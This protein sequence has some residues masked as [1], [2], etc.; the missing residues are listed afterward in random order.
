MAKLKLIAVGTTNPN[1]E[2]W[3]AWEDVELYLA[4][5]IEEA[6]KM[7]GYHESF[8]AV[9]VDMTKKGHVM[10]YRYNEFEEERL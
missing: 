3:T 1:P 4:E 7:A 2:E 8:M 6:V 9:E 10:T 5:S